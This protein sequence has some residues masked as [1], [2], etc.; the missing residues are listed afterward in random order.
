[1]GL[2]KKLFIKKGYRLTVVNAPDQFA[3]P[4][5]EVDGEVEA[6]AELT[7]SFDF[8]LVF[9]HSQSELQEYIPQAL[10]HLKETG[11]LWVAYPKKSS[12][13]KSDISRDQGWEPLHEAG[14]EGCSLISIDDTWSGM[15]FRRIK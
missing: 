12:K 7:G 8:I 4:L 5:E 6:A 13:I 11:N 3:L 1:M 2:A 9:A 15:R 14:Y 10:P